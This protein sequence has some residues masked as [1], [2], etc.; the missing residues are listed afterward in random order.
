[1]TETPST[2][3]SKDEPLKNDIRAN[4]NP[5]HQLLSKPPH[6]QRHCRMC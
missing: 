2:D 4:T 1:M 6:R 5:N 3:L